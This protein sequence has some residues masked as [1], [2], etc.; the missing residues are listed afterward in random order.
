MNQRNKGTG[1]P[2]QFFKSHFKQALFG[3]CFSAVL[4]PDLSLWHRNTC[5]AAAVQ[6]DST[7]PPE[8]QAKSDVGFQKIDALPVRKILLYSSGVAQVFHAGTV[9]G[10]VECEMRFGGHD[11][12]D[13]LKSLVIDD[14][15]GTRQGVEYQ[16]APSANRV[17]AQELETPLTFA[18]YLQKY[19]GETV[20]FA[21]DGASLSGVVIGVENRIVSGEVFET[22]VYL[23]QNQLKTVALNQI[24]QLEFADE[25]L[26]SEFAAALQGLVE[27]RE[28]QH[29]QLR[30][31]FEGS[32]EREIQYA[33][34]IDAPLWRI[35]YRMNMN[36]DGKAKLQ[37]WVHL[38]NVFSYDWKEIEVELRDG[39]PGV[40]HSEL[41]APVLAERTSDGFKAFDFPKDITLVQQWYGF[42][43][44]ARF[45]GQDR[46]RQFTGGIYG[47]SG[48]FG[49]GFGG[50]SGGGMGGY[51]PP[52]DP[53]SLE[54]ENVALQANELQETG[55]SIVLELEDRVTVPAGTSKAVPLFEIDVEARHVNRFGFGNDRKTTEGRTAIEFVNQS[56][57]TFIPGPVEIQ[58]D[59]Y[60]IGDAKIVR[61][62]VGE[63]ASIAFGRDAQTFASTKQVDAITRV[64]RV[65]RQD[66]K[67]KRD[68]VSTSDLEISIT[69]SSGK[70]RTAEVAVNKAPGAHL[71]PEPFR[72]TSTVAIYRFE[73]DG[74]S[75]KNQK[76]VVTSAVTEDVSLSNAVNAF[77]QWLRDQVE[78]DGETKAYLELATKKLEGLEETR[79][80]VA[81]IKNEIISLRSDQSRWADLAEKLAGDLEAKQK[82]SRL[83]VDA[84]DRLL[85]MKDEVNG[86][87][88]Q[89]KQAQEGFYSMDKQRD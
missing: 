3:L 77:P 43:P 24:T 81:S 75:E 32:G 10:N 21:V 36:A 2:M 85:L 45:E 33:Y 82:F 16:A 78:M 49:G 63:L 1:T 38:D 41:F 4:V 64:V 73:L 80:K 74:H 9:S 66:G 17:A 30:L 70:K 29:R 89:L 51:V 61:T 31:Q 55:Y 72:Q 46:G 22:L 37:G 26:R 8:N 54:P 76:V 60:F 25:A 83:V 53:R 57:T 27:E 48:S 79:A 58:E 69:N 40:F 34:V 68:V 67:I 20:Q 71:E 62:P 65:F 52:S 59:G 12:D 47:G 50:G 5:L 23:D 11:V 35:T 15:D 19:R 44:P 6:E 56:G 88:E 14:P 84:E 13:V 7:N 28:S 86:L 87:D 39:R 42:P 18:Q